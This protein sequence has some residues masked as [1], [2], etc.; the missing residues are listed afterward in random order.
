MKE[1]S[2]EPASK[3]F[4]TSKPHNGLLNKKPCTEKDYSRKGN[5]K[6]ISKYRLGHAYCVSAHCPLLLSFALIEF[7]LL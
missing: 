4:Q 5:R 1:R 2:E 3:G 6:Q 7:P